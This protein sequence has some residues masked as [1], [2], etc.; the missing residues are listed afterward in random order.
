MSIL[1]VNQLGDSESKYF[2]HHNQFLWLHLLE[3][4]VWG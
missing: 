4:H 3:A 2:C 1:A